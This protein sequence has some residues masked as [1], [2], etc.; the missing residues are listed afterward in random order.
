[1]PYWSHGR[2][3]LSCLK[4]LA[5]FLSRIQWHGMIQTMAGYRGRC[6]LW[7]TL[8]LATSFIQTRPRALVSAHPRPF[9]IYSL[10]KHI[11]RQAAGAWDQANCVCTYLCCQHTLEWTYSAVYAQHIQLITVCQ[12]LALLLI[13]SREGKNILFYCFQVLSWR[14]VPLR[15]ST[16]S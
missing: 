16:S 12:T 4:G 9:L 5:H 11:W 15:N 8:V 6:Y 3:K 13:A 10:W 7:W 14:C 1:M 2:R